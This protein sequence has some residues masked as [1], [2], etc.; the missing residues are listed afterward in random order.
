M[1]SEKPDFEKIYRELFPKI[2]AYLTRLV[3]DRDAEDVTQEVFIKV[4]AALDNLRGDSSLSTWIYRIA[5]NAAMDHLRKKPSSRKDHEAGGIPDDDLLPEVCVDTN[6][7]SVLSL[8]TRAIRKEMNSCIR[9]IVDGLPGNYRTV[10]VLSELEGLTNSEIA[11]VLQV[12][13]DT[14][15]IRLHRARMRLKKELG[16]QCTFYRDERNELACDRKASPVVFPRNC[17]YPFPPPPR[18]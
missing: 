4:N 3:G 8:D 15:K 18:L 2:A 14:V 10:L 17:V 7:E 11:E 16:A 6:E 1:Q 13:L 5:T 12:S 9:G